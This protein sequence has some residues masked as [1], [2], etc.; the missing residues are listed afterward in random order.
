MGAGSKASVGDPVAASKFNQGFHKITWVIDSELSTGKVDNIQVPIT[1]AHTIAEV[2]AR[3][4]QAPAGAAIRLDVLKNGT[5]IHTADGDKCAIAAGEQA[6][7]TTT[8]SDAALADGDYLELEIEQVGS[9][10]SGTGLVCVVEL[11]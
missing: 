11:E 5:S 7:A 8:F 10:S 4:A 9:S 1:A 2:H 3:V 6:G